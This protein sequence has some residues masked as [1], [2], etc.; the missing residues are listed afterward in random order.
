M[1]VYLVGQNFP[2][3]G[4]CINSVFSTKDKALIRLAQLDE[5]EPSC[6]GWSWFLMEIELDKEYEPYY[7]PSNYEFVGKSEHSKG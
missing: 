7:S 2:C 6:G 4:D 1:L 5:K 3:E